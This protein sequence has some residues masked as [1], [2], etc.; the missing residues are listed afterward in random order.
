[1]LLGGEALLLGATPELSGS[2]P[3]PWA[4]SEVARGLECWFD[5]TLS[6]QFPWSCFCSKSFS[7]W[8][9]RR[10]YCVSSLALGCPDPCLAGQKGSCK[11]VD[12]ARK[13]WS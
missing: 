2:A 7:R 11:Y 5:A 4:R 6:P 12:R 9:P 3:A 10:R 8:D 13:S 1:M